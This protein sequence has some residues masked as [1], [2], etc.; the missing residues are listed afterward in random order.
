[1]T[2]SQSDLLFA[3]LKTFH[4]GDVSDQEDDEEEQEGAPQTEGREF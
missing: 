1:M 3:F 4:R 2:F